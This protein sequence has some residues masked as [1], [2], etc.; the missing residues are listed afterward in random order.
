LKSERY[1]PQWSRLLSLARSLDA[2]LGLGLAA[3]VTDMRERRDPDA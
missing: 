1:F 3:I 2:R